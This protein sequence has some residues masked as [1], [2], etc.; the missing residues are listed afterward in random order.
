M[1][2]SDYVYIEIWDDDMKD[3]DLIGTV[4]I[5]GTELIGRKEEIIEL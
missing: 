5:R 3:D 2:P 4:K 1:N